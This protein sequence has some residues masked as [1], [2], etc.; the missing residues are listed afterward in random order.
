MQ[1]QILRELT[2]NR[3]CDSPHI[4]RYYTSFLTLDSSSIAICMEYCAGRSLDNVYKQVKERGGRTGERVLGKI[5][6]GVLGGLAYL[7][8]RKI[9]HRGIFLLLDLT[10]FRHKT[11]E[12]S[13]YRRR[14]CQIVR[15]WSLWR[16][17]R[18]T[19]RDIYRNIILYGCIVL[20]V[21]PLL[22][23]ARENTGRTIFSG[24]RYLVTG[25]LINGSC[26]KPLPVS[27]RHR[28]SFTTD[29]ITT[30]HRQQSR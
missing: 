27:T 11:I 29:R 18:F 15:L 30:I 28:S 9:I 22:M 13:Y 6:C 16:I 5:A 26:P 1:R 24:L 8:E 12:Y 20:I 2:F 17:G 10:N 7:H 3:S 19:C 21:L 23:I 4:V 14:E 25:P